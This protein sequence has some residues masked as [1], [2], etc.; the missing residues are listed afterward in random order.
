M[1]ARRIPVG[2]PVI[3]GDDIECNSAMG[4]LP[5]NRRCLRTIPQQHES[6]EHTVLLPR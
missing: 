6:K 3:D 1:A 4:T 5:M 2:K